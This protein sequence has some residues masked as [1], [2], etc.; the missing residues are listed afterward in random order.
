MLCR[1]TKS[2]SSAESTRQVSTWKRQDL[3]IDATTSSVIISARFLHLLH[4]LRHRLR[5]QLQV[6]RAMSERSGLPADQQRK[7]MCNDLQRWAL[8]LHQAMST[9][10]T[11]RPRLTKLRQSSA[12]QQSVFHRVSFLTVFYEHHRSHLQNPFVKV[13]SFQHLMWWSGFM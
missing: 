12:Q 2:A 6:H 13:L 10:P 4:H 3:V 5:D 8:D 1:R 7:I 9:E 11:L